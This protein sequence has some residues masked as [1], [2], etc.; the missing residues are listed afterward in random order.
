MTRKSAF[1]EDRGV[2]RVSGEDAAGFLHN[3][4]TN[5]VEALEIGQ[6]RYAALLTPQ[7]K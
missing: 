6:A 7:G 1:L 2:V 5:D 4:V 3:L